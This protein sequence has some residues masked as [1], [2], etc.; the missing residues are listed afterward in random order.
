[1]RAMLLEV[2][3]LLVLVGCPMGPGAGNGPGHGQTSSGSVVVVDGGLVAVG[4]ASFP[5]LVATP[6]ASEGPFA[7]STVCASCHSNAPGA[8]AMKDAQG[9][10]VAPHDLWR[11]TMMAN[12]A[13]DPLFRAQLSVEVQQTPTRA[14]DIE[15]TCQTCHDPMG[16]RLDLANNRV[17]PP[18]ASV[19]GAS[20]R[21]HLALDGV[22]C[23]VCHA[24][25]AQDLGTPESFSGGFHITTTGE[26]YGP[27]DAPFT[28]PMQ[29]HTG[30]TPAKGNHVLESAA[31]ATC[32]TLFTAQLT[33]DGNATGAH[34]AEQSPYLEWRNSSYST[35]RQPGAPDARSCQDCHMDRFNGDGTPITTRIAR[36]PN[37]TDFPQITTRSPYGS[38]ALVGGNTLVPALLKGPAAA[39]QPGVP[40]AAF[41]A[42][43]T[44]TRDQLSQRT[45]SIS[46]GTVSISG[47]NLTIP[48]SITVATGHKFPSGY[49]SRRAFVQLVVRD[50]SGAAV[51]VSGTTN[52][53]GQLVDT[54]GGVLPSELPGGPELP[55]HTTITSPAQVQVYEAVLAGLDGT[56]TPLLLR[57]GAHLK[58]NRL[59]PLGFVRGGPDAAHVDPV[60]TVDDGDFVGGGDALTYEVTLPPGTQ[61]ARVEAQLLFQVLGARHAAELLAFDTPEV[62]A[63]G[64]ALGLVSMAPEPVAS[65]QRVLP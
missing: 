2:T 4:D 57:A 3:L 47:Q 53:R 7:T 13:R 31:C 37:G 52:S 42:V 11:A 17:T 64:A 16:R 40:A 25:T 51:W 21:D 22:S 46:I 30:F 34:H 15:A 39:L 55:H 54:S 19:T 48:V 14:Q 62:A 60:G 49:P 61:A 9:N 27:H 65:A 63:L 43:I 26:L 50:P 35:E 24:M 29:M 38:H 10:G 28:N 32:H 6:E 41:D 18:L 45:A 44:A 36:R 5:G 12:A 56:R 20:A 59:L 8:A 58:D 23:T 33:A 1:M